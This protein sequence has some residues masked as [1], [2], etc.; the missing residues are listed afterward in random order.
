MD[1]NL[2]D[3]MDA[4]EDFLEHFGV[5]GMKWGVRRDLDRIRSVATKSHEMGLVGKRQKVKAE[6]VPSKRQQKKID[7]AEYK[8][9]RKDAMGTEKANKAFQ[10]AAKS[11]DKPLKAINN[12][13]AFKGKDLDAPENRRLRKTYDEV[14]SEVFNEHLAQASI[15]LTY[16][17][18]TERAVIYRFD[19]NVGM[20]KATEVKAQWED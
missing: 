17:P 4:G 15:N 5:K 7:K 18:K 3:T 13:P 19:S 6:G 9:W 11:F 10:D 1:D 2:K 14:V 8:D 20:M 16:N 12:D